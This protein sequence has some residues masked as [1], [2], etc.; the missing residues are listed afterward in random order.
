MK[1]F[2]SLLLKGIV[3]CPLTAFADV[4][5]IHFNV[6]MGDST[7]IIDTESNQTMLVDAGNRG[8]GGKVIL[9]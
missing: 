8:K 4:E 1:Y 3:V 9:T 6:G 2:L 5:I 7:L